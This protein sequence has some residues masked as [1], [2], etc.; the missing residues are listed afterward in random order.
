VES[1]EFL[2]CRPAT[3]IYAALEPINVASVLSFMAVP[4]NS[5]YFS[6]ALKNAQKAEEDGEQGY[7]DHTERCS[8]DLPGLPFR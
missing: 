2:K 7:R 4:I 6:S 1:T 8:G 5:V 3:L